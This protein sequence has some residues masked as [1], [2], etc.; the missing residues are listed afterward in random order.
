MERVLPGEELAVVE[1]DGEEIAAVERAEEGR[2]EVT[3][4]AR[5]EIV[6]AQTAVQLYRIQSEYP[7]MKGYV[8]SAGQK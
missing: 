8:P 7:V 5:V 2:A 4:L 3:L 1:K 6:Y